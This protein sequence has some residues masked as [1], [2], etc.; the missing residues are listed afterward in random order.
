[1]LA[2]IVEAAIRSLLLGAAIWLGLKLLR[3]T[4]PHILMAVWQL[5][6]VLSLCMPMLVDWAKLMPPSASL[7]IPQMLAAD[8]TFF[9]APPMQH[10]APQVASSAIDWRMLCSA[11]Y[12]IVA[13]F[14][15]LRLLVGAV[16]IAK[17]CHAALPV[18]ENWTA[19][20]DVRASDRVKVPATFGSTIVLPS[21]YVTWDVTL[22]R[23]VMAHE[24]AHVAHG[25][26]FVLLLAAVNRA[27]FWFSP[28]AWWLYDQLGYLAEARSDAAAIADIEDRVRYAEILIG[29]G[30]V[31]GRTPA[32]LAMAG[33]KTVPRRVE[34]I[35]AQT[36]L[37]HRMNWKAWS[38]IVACILP[39]AAIAAGV[40]AQQPS[41]T[42]NIEFVAPD[43]ATLRQRRAEQQK[44]RHEVQ[45]DPALL[46]NYVGYYRLGP[47]PY[48]VFAVT[49]QDDH[50]LVRFS[51][52]EA[53]QVYPE[54]SQDFFYKG[55]AAQISFVTD[56][57]GRATAL[58]YHQNGLD[59]PAPRIDQ[60]QAQQ[61]ADTLA[62]RVKSAAPAAGTEA[63]LR[64]Q[65]EAFQQDTP[66]FDAMTNGLATITRP[67]VPKIERQFELLGELQ[68]LSFRGVGF[69]GWDIYEAK[70][71]N[72]IT[73]CRILLTPDNKITGLRFEWGP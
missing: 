68:S 31:S 6:L 1:M 19:G 11:I 70:F 35:L 30:A 57:Q 25:D 64:H 13:A 14:L 56:P 58:V 4:N 71:A 55:L 9:A 45:I 72:G 69:E 63:A 36:M 52:P 8:P 21:G 29:F 47:A 51:G 16:L 73:I 66:D 54:D 32:V 46:D 22:R 15:L 2:L 5:V 27:I 23:A 44:P 62:Q 50:L 18:R 34:C 10:A 59:K 53:V 41:K 67:Q 60:A 24:D 48:R 39:L 20:R 42:E 65:I 28:L 37:P 26:F 7:Q 38:A 61:I 49:R 40:I 12:L 17:L 3:I 43:Q 33:T